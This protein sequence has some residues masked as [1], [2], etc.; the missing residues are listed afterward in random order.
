[1]TC[2]TAESE[3]MSCLSE[4][5]GTF[6]CCPTDFGDDPGAADTACAKPCVYTH[7]RGQIAAPPRAL[8]RNRCL[9]AFQGPNAI[10]DNQHTTHQNMRL[11][12]HTTLN[13]RGN[14]ACRAECRGIETLPNL[15][16]WKAIR[17]GTPQHR[18]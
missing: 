18:V 11:S 7:Q 10:G 14:G 2:E 12:G 5:L 17:C 4:T 9:R 15:A 16:Y 3:Q 13:G 1:M 8:F 6:A